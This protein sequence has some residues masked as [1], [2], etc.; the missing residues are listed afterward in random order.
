[1]EKQKRNTKEILE[2]K[3]EKGGRVW[4]SQTPKIVAKKGEGGLLGE[5]SKG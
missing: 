1:M 2:K 3:L 5:R 4:G